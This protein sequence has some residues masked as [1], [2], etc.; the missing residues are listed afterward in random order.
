MTGN[1]DLGLTKD[2]SLSYL[3]HVILNT[4]VVL[5]IDK[6]LKYD[7]NTNILHSYT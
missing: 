6:L 7:F 4:N 1:P 3:N 2:K 5:C